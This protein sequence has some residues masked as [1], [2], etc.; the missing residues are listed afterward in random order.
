MDQQILLVN[1]ARSLKFLK[2]YVDRQAQIWKIFQRHQTIPDNIQ[3]LHFHIDDFK[4][5]IEKEFTFLKEA[6]RKNV[7][8]F[9]SSLNLQQ[10]YSPA[11]CSHVNNIYNK[12][13]EI[14]QQLPH[15]NPHMNIGNVIQIEVPGFDPDIDEALP[16][17]T[18]QDTND[19]ITQGSEKHTLQTADKVIECR[20]PAPPCQN[21]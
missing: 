21:I 12:L 10:M 9:Q 18:D 3:D 8:N 11:L 13:A 2:N 15:P 7:E 20:A 5:N 1:T 4:S 14:Q 16:T 6:T 17:P 19:P